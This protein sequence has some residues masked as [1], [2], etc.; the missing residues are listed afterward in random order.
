MARSKSLPRA[1]H[2][3]P[4]MKHSD[5]QSQGSLTDQDSHSSD[6]AHG[7]SSGK[8][9]RPALSSKVAQLRIELAKRDSEVQRLEKSLAEAVAAQG[10]VAASTHATGAAA[11]R[12]P[13]S[14]SGEP[15]PRAATPPRSKAMSQQSSDSVPPQAMDSALGLLRTLVDGS[16]SKVRRRLPFG[17]DSSNPQLSTLQG[18]L[19]GIQTVVES[20]RQALAT[21]AQGLESEREDLLI[22]VRG[23]GRRW[24]C[25]DSMHILPI[26]F[27][28]QF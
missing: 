21:K 19:Q 17:S 14:S 6:T 9:E 10:R 8:G 5:A 23:G 25:S 7:S 16:V 4:G 3:S 11:G 13:S 15:L 28:S 12:A 20:D 27:W 22:Q 24:R 18:V 1:Q 26:C 2:S